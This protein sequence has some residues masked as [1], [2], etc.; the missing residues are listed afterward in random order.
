MTTMSKTYR[1]ADEL[2]ALVLPWQ[3]ETAAGVF[4][5]LDLTSGY[6]FTVTLINSAGTALT[7]A[8]TVVGSDGAVTITWATNDLDIAATT[9]RL[10]LVARHTATSKDRTW[11]PGKPFSITIVE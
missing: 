11:S 5:D 3:E 10:R 4:E 7:P 8:P 1:R 2:P 9:Y 6:T